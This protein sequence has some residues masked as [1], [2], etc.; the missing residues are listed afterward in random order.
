MVLK[1]Y[2]YKRLVYKAINIDPHVYNLL[3]Q[4]FAGGYTHANWIYTD[5]I[6]KDIDSYDFTSS[7]PYIMVTHKFPMSEFR[8]CYIKDVKDMNKRICYLLV[9][10]LYDVKCKY[11]NNFISLSK[12]RNVR[13]G[14]YD[15]GR[16]MS[17]D[18]LEITITDVD[19]YFILDTYKC[20]YEILEIYYSTYNYLPKQ[21]INFVLDKYINKTK[22]KDVDGKE[23]EYSITEDEIKEYW[24]NRE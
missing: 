17:C 10:K 6:L 12:C 23:I 2:H 4:A 7:Y 19:F 15:N 20:K 9:V 13:G 16:I 24:K 5:E 14:K 3:I 11:F 1:D 8:R 18:E 21:F 22:F